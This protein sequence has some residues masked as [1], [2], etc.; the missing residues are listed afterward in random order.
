MTLRELLADVELTALER[1]EASILMC[2]LK[3]AS[4]NKT[5]KSARNGG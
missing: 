1:R 3:G 2:V 4:M 5:D